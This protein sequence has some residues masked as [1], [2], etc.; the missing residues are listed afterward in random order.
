MGGAGDGAPSCSRGRRALRG[1]TRAR[2]R[3]VGVRGGRRWSLGGQGRRRASGGGDGGPA[4]G[5]RRRRRPS[6]GR[7]RASGGRGRERWR[8]ASG[9]RGGDGGPAAAI[10]GWRRPSDGPAMTVLRWGTAAGVTGPAAGVRRWGLRTAVRG[11]A[12]R[13]P[14][15]RGGGR[16]PPGGQGRRTAGRR[17]R[18]AGDGR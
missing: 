12:V 5:V 7:R 10:R 3:A 9:G 18:P 16:W 8:R 15:G 4:A 17:P 2:W 14:A 1:V 6:G 13:G 11:A